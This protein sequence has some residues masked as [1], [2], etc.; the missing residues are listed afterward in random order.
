MGEGSGGGG[1]DGAALE[2]Q[3]GED[4][5]EGDEEGDGGEGEPAGAEGKDDG[6]EDD[7]EDGDGEEPAPAPQ[8]QHEVEHRLLLD[9]EVTEG[10]A[11]L[12]LPPAARHQPLFRGGY[13]RR[14]AELV[15]DHLHRVTALHLQRDRAPRHRLDEDL[16]PSLSLSLS[17]SLSPLVVLS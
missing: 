2:A 7:D 8:A 5:E 10:H 17:L 15:L 12:Q 16:H 9:V 4:E 14:E 11:L 13:G 3:A 1:G 6:K